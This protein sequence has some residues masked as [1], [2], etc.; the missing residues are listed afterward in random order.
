MEP[1]PLSAITAVA[2]VAQSAE[3]AHGVAWVVA[4][5]TGPD[6]WE[7]IWWSQFAGVAR[8]TW[9]HK[10]GKPTGKNWPVSISV[11][12]NFTSVI[13][14]GAINIYESR[15]LPLSYGGDRS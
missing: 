5:T 8:W 7:A 4:L 3:L 10:S 14:I 15:A 2:V 1:V 13:F 12:T 6:G 11:A 9:P